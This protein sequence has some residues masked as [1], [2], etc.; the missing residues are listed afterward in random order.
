M[1]KSI[2][3]SDLGKN[4]YK[5][6]D[7][8]LELD[9][10]IIGGGITGISCAYSLLDSGLKTALVEANLIGEGVT[11]RT[12]GKI[13][14]LQENVYSKIKKYVGLSAS[15]L[16]FKSQKEAI[17]TIS[18]IIKKED[19]ACDFIKCSS[20]VFT[21]SSKISDLR[22]EKKILESFGAKVYEDVSLPDGSSNKYNIYVDDTYVFHPLK[23]LYSLKKIISKK[24]DIYENSRI[25]KISKCDNYY[26]CMSDKY[27]IKTKRIVLASHYPYFIFPFFMMGK[28]WLEKSYVSAFKVDNFLDFSAINVDKD[29]ISLRYHKSGE[30]I[31]KIYLYGSHNIC[32]KIYKN[33]SDDSLYSWTNM[34][35]MTGD[36][37]PFIGEISKDFFLATGYNTWGMTNGIIA[38]SVIHDLILGKDSLYKE[39]FDPRRSINLVRILNYFKALSSNVLA[40]ITTMITNKNKYCKLEKID[41]KYVYTYNKHMV[42]ARC[43]HLGCFLVLNKID[44]TWDCPCHGSRF[45]IDGRCIDGPSNYNISYK[46]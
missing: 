19:I 4:Y 46:K 24:I 27:I 30:D 41:G 45:S 14:Y 35:I 25:L 36:H 26:M 37:L 44:N 22:D 7:K 42:Y 15:K 18:N 11:S 34:D 2:W 40:Y 13:T 21:N 38:G 29:V 33:I 9:V 43:P 20:Y 8:D 1:G 16:Y 10:L 28:V 6:L 23:Y 3:L 17:K 12:T 32:N 39:L 5:E 31:Y